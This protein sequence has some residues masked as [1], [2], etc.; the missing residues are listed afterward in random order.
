MDGFVKMLVAA[1]SRVY[2][3]A[4]DAVVQA[5]VTRQPVAFTFHDVLAIAMPGDSVH[6]VLEDWSIDFVAGAWRAAGA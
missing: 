5:S 2:E 4:V 3:I 6:N 1:G